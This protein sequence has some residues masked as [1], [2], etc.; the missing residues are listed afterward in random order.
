MI[1]HSEVDQFRI[2]LFADLLY[3]TKYFYEILN[4][5]P[6]NTPQPI[7][8]QSHYSIIVN[9]LQNVFDLQCNRLIINIPPGHGKSTMLVYF[10]AWAMAQYPDSHFLYISYSSEL[11]ETHTA[12]IKQIMSLPEYSKLFN[13]SIDRNFSSRGDFRTLQGGRIVAKGSSGTITGLNAG[14]PYLDRFS[15]MAIIDDAHKPDE[16]HSDTMR[17]SVI[18]NYNQTIKPRPRS[19][20]VPMVYIGHRL[21]ER[22]LPGFL[23]EGADGHHWKTVILQAIDGAGNALCPEIKSLEWLHI[24][25]ETNQYVFTSQYQQEPQPPGGGLFLEA[26]FI[27]LPEEPPIICTFLTCDTAETDKSY[28]DATVFSFWGLY[29]IGLRGLQTDV[30]A[31]HWIDC[32]ELWLKPADLESEL[33]DF[34]AAC[35]RHPMKPRFVAVEKK[36]TGVTLL[37][38]LGKIQGLQAVDIERTRASGSKTARHIEM[39]PFVGKKLIT[40]PQYAAHTEKCIKHMGKIT[41]NNTHLRDDICDSAYDAVKIALIDRML[42]PQENKADAFSK[43]L[44]NRHAEAQRY[45]NQ[46]NQTSW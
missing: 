10:V 38:A 12:T 29:K 45:R 33:L 41:A 26:D 23:I 18:N 20:N 30:Y 14:L 21:H 42:I 6:F 27:A 24:E 13:V 11:A 19:D 16:V 39:C 2:D 25:R 46:R 5:R 4:A 31:L 44:A 28:N 17:D 40:L 7:G 8:R 9:E 36:S 34:Y 32:R 15:G 22:D 1:Q 37:S 3:F 43:L 35:M